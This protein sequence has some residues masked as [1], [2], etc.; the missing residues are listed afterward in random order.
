MQAVPPI[1]RSRTE[2]CSIRSLKQRLCVVLPLFGFAKLGAVRPACWEVGRPA[3]PPFGVG[4]DCS[5]IFASA[6]SLPFVLPFVFSVFVKR[7]HAARSYQ[8]LTLTTAV[9]QSRSAVLVGRHLAT[10]LCA[11]LYEL[12]IHV[13]STSASFIFSILRPITAPPSII[14]RIPWTK[15]HTIPNNR[16]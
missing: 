12:E 5:G 7:P 11:V 15:L 13:L 16:K 14:V 1:F 10:F 2:N 3:P 9:E 6:L 8:S 4:R